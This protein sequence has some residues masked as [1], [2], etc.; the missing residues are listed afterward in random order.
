M[1]DDVVTGI[2]DEVVVIEQGRVAMRDVPSRI[3]LADLERRL[4]VA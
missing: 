2:A 3:S 1:V 4:Y